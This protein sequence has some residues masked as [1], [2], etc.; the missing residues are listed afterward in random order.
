MNIG[1]LGTGSIAGKLAD[2]INRV[3]GARLY[4]VAS[5]ELDKSRSFAEK[6]GATVWF[7]NY[8]DLYKC[9]DVDL[10]YVATPN[11]FHK[12]HTIDALNNNKAVLCEKPFALDSEESKEMIKTAK[13]NDLLLVEA[14]WTKY[15]PAVKKLKEVVD[16]GALGDIVTVQGD[17][18]YPMGSDKERLIRK[19]LGGGALLDLGVYPITLTHFILGKPDF[20]QAS[21]TMASTGVDESTY[22]ILKY[23]SGAQ[24]I[25]STSFN[26]VST[27]EFLVCG[28]KGWIRLNDNLGYPK[29]ISCFIEGVGEEHKQFPW[30]YLGYEYQVQ[31]L[32]EDFEKGVKESSTVRISDTLEIM[33]ILDNIRAIIGLDFNE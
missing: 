33:D 16:S 21:A 11:S 5:R 20:I 7:G 18:S 17:L 6:Y 3:E 32:V 30:P 25:L 14:M 10:V 2:A 29:S 12:R 26:A 19:D 23:N 8:E 1:I 28:T 24:A 15:F 13:E 22:V 31:G 9:D 4:A 27:K